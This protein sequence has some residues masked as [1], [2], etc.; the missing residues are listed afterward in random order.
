MNSR[1]IRCPTCGRTTSW[2]EAPRGP[3]CSD[4]CR[5]IDLGN[6]ADETY[7]MPADDGGG[8]DP[9]TVV[10]GDNDRTE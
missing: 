8:E 1:A 5:L 4:R 2:E 10:T 9:Y 6:W 3:F 7:R